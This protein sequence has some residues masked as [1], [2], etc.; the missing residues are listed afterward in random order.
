MSISTVLIGV[1]SGFLPSQVDPV[2][3]PFRNVLVS[4]DDTKEIGSS[5]PENF[6][7]L[8]TSPVGLFITVFELLTCKSS[9]TQW[10]LI[11]FLLD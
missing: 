10:I 8:G 5:L 3:V 4:S 1:L 7:P 9:C 11:N 6:V 2:S